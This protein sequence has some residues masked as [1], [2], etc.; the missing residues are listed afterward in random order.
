[1]QVHGLSWQHS[2]VAANSI[3]QAALVEDRVYLP[4]MHMDYELGSMQK[5]S[6]ATALDAQAWGMPCNV[7][8][9]HV[10]KRMRSL[11]S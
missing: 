10:R 2:A 1:M 9:M 11:Q 8:M 6:F 7:L 4:P 5:T 3:T